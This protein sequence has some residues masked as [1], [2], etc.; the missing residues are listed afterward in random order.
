M[1][2]SSQKRAIHPIDLIFLTLEKRRQ[3][4]HVGGLLMFELPKNAPDTF[5]QDLVQ[6][7]RS[8]TQPPVSPF[9]DRLQGLYWQT[10]ENFDIDHHFKHIALPKPGRIRELFVYISQEH[11]SLLDRAKPMWTC[12][13]IEGIEGR[14]FAI[15]VKIHHAVVDGIG[16]MRLL[17]KS[18]SKTPKDTLHVPL[19]CLHY[20]RKH[21]TLNVPYSMPSPKKLSQRIQGLWHSSHRV[22]HELSQ[23]FQERKYNPEHISTFNA[24]KS[25]FNQRVT[26]SRRFAAQSFELLR[27]RKIADHF[28]V[29]MND[30]ILAICSGALREYLRCYD[31][32]PKKPLVAMVPASVRHDNSDVSN[33]ITMILA[34]LATHLDD[35]IDRL[36]AIQRSVQY[37]K[38]RFSRLSSNE[39]LNYSAF[40]YSAMGMHVLSGFFPKHQSFNLVISNIISAKEPLYLNGAKLEALYPASVLLDGQA[41]NITMSSYLDKLEVGIIACRHT[42][43]K[44][45]SLLKYLE[46]SI[47]QYEHIIQ[48]SSSTET[49]LKI[50]LF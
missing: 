23:N 26:A 49:D 30:V 31:T 6:K 13:L 5:I 14:R 46:Q 25:I 10:D 43:P 44:I 15:Y 36:N 16:A 3:P 39:I 40:V 24:P 33:R 45:Q 17:E 29:K 9:N 48:L 2:Q 11:S 22:F 28:G 50:S 47:Q 18:L 8:S 27:L 38:N 21:D 41:L 34:S 37:A 7:I 4:M 35:P 42:L 32:L 12:T 20:E 19:W 1:S